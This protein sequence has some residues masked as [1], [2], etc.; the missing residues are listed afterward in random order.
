MSLVTG[1]NKHLVRFLGGCISPKICIIMEHCSNGS[2]HQFLKDE[3]KT[4][5]WP[6]FFK[7]ARDITDGLVALH[8]IDPPIVHRDLKSLNIMLDD[9]W[10]IKLI[11]F[12]LARQVTSANMLGTLG[13]M[14][15][16]VGWL[17]N[18]YISF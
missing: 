12:G 7:F 9:N 14:V 13:N 10:D 1:K 2:L 5:D 18:T 4:V 11:D 3:Q 8:S 15:G 6:L 16:T 17:G